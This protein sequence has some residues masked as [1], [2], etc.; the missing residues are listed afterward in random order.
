MN[1]IE[2]QNVSKTYNKGEAE[3]KALAS[4]DIKIAREE[5]V[6]IMGASG[7]GKTTLLNI[8]GLLDKPNN[9]KYV[10]DNREITNETSSNTLSLLRRDKIGFVFQSFNLLPRSSALD[11]VI[12]P[13]IYSGL[14]DR[15]KIANKLLSQVGLEKR[16]R[17]LP[18]QLSGGEKQRVAIARALINNPTIILAD[19]PTGNL[20]T[21]SGQE[22]MKIFSELNKNKGITIVMITHEPDIAKYAQRTIKMKDGEII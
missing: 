6:A 12:M 22:I 10:L 9:G 20:D 16:T 18:N 3:I 7:S 13:A 21:K 19:E 4:V 1:I 17:H 2:L 8:I 5:F 15:A 14:K 11:N